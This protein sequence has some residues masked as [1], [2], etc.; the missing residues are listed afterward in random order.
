MKT[1][2][3]PL[4]ALGCASVAAAEDGVAVVSKHLARPLGWS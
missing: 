1:S 4:A 2:V 3:A